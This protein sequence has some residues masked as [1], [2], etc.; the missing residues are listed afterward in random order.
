MIHHVALGI[1]ATHAWTR[2]ATLLIET[3]QIGGTICAADAL[4]S[5]IGWAAYVTLQAATLCAVANIATLRIGATWRGLAGI[6]HILLHWRW[7]R[8]ACDEGIARVGAQAA[9]LWTMVQHLALGIQA[10]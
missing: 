4:G 3:C 9:A 8:V 2:I 7:L 6:S 1:L 5:A 10:T